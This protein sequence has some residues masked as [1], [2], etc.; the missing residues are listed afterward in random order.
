MFG[1]QLL[2]GRS[3]R[4]YARQ[5]SNTRTSSAGTKQK[6]WKAHPLEIDERSH[7]FA[8]SCIPCSR[9]LHRFVRLLNRTSATHKITITVWSS[10]TILCFQNYVIF[11]RTNMCMYIMNMYDRVE[12]GFAN[13]GQLRMWKGSI[14]CRQMSTHAR[15]VRSWTVV[16]HTQ[17]STLLHS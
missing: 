4:S 17:R 7:S 10:A 12:T 14:P 3:Q 15:C 16:I 8:S 6:R 13:P 2:A 1:A 11:E 5:D 9:A